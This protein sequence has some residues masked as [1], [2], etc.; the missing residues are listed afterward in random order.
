MQ[1]LK[2]RKPGYM[3]IVRNIPRQHIT[4][5]YLTGL[6]K[7]GYADGGNVDVNIAE[8]GVNEAPN[9][10]VKAYSPF[11]TDYNDDLPFGGVDMDG[12]KSGQ[13]MLTRQEM[14]Q[15]QQ[16][17]PQAPT[18]Q[19][20]APAPQGGSNILQMTPQ[21]RAMAAMQPPAPAQPKPAGMKRGGKVT[22]PSTDGMRY[23]ITVKSKKAK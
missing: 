19:G 8:V 11:A 1:Q 13:Q 9:L 5:K 21:G 7:A 20:Q 10:P 16:P 18:P 15:A 23:A 12:S 4:E 14:Q 3:D 22:M 2:G 6:Q 17:A